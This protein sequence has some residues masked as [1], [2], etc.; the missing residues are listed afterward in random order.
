MMGY[1]HPLALGRSFVEDEGIP[2][3]DRVMLLTYR[4]WQ[5]RFGGDPTIVGRAIRLDNELYTV[6]GVLGEGPADR[7]QSKIWLPMAFTPE[8]LASDDL[9]L[10]VMGRLRSGVTIQQADDNLAAIVPESERAARQR[11]QYSSSVQPFRNNFLR[12]ST[13]QGLWLLLAAVG[14]LLLIACANV[15]NLLLARGSA[16]QRELA[17]RAALGASNGAIARQLLIDSLVLAFAAGIA[18]ALFASVLLDGIV[19]L[20]PE[21]TL[22]SETEITLSVPVLLFAFAACAI[23]GALSGCAP[24]WQAARAN[25]VDAIKEGGRAIGGGRHVLRR[26][27]VVLEFALALTLLAGGGLAAH[28]FIKTMSV[29]LGYRTDNVLTMNLPVPR[30]RFTA[31]EAV[32]I[33]YRELLDRTANVPGIKSASISTGMPLRGTGFGDGVEI[34]GRTK[35]PAERAPSGVNMVTPR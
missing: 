17:L 29:D 6:V 34:V 32:E 27:L 1:G 14:F 4:L 10:H 19:A 26:V 30:G 18:G 8:Q 22:P 20:M 24:A 35:D 21:Y 12:S 7:Q 16:R 11:Q 23:S 33:F 2:G 9:S 15:A 13:K 3:R 28:A 31:P 25:L 5:D